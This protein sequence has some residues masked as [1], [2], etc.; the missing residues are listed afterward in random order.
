MILSSYQL[1]DAALKLADKTYI[2]T[3]PSSKVFWGFIF[4]NY[5][6]AHSKRSTSAS[7]GN[8]YGS[9]TILL[10]HGCFRKGEGNMP[11][12]EHLK[13]STVNYTNNN[14]IRRYIAS[15]PYIVSTVLN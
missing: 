10:A 1:I 6:K 4:H 15:V 13:H 2:I 14:E 3:K 9:Y 8:T 7:S 5:T 11:S 12:P